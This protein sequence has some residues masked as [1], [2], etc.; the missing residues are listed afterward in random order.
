VTALRGT[1]L[2]LESLMMAG[3]VISGNNAIGSDHEVDLQL[4]ATSR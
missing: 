4:A 2:R 3:Y 1:K